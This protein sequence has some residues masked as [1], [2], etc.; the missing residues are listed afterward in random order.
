[1]RVNSIS[2]ERIT[3]AKAKE[4]HH[5]V[6]I[7]HFPDEETK[8]VQGDSVPSSR[9]YSLLAEDMEKL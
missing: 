7:T 5:P 9:S 3:N 8:A 4:L 2:N 1:M 6:Q